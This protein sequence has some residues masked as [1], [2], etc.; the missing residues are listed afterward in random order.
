MARRFGVPLSTVQLWVKRAGDT[1]L[2]DVDW[3]DRSSAPARTRRVET[4]VEDRVLAAR[5]YLRD[6]TALG[7]WGAVAIHGHLIHAFGEAPSVRTIGRI[8]ER[9]GALDGSARIRR[10]PPKPGWYLK[11]VRERQAEL[12]SFDTVMGLV[13][14]NG[15]EV[16]VL[17]GVSLHGGVVA[18]WP[19]T[20][21]TARDTVR[22][23]VE[24]WREM[25]L[26]RYAQFD[27]DTRFQ[28]A[29]HHRDA[30][31]RVTRLCLSLGVVPVFVP[32]R[33]PGFQGAIE[34]YNG[35][36]QAKVWNRFHH[37]SLLALQRRSNAYVRAKRSRG[38]VRAEAA[39][40]RRQFPK[41][42][43]LDLNQPLRGRVVYIRRTNDASSVEL[44]GHRFGVRTEWPHRLVRADIELDEHIIHFY[45]LRRRDPEHQPLLR[46]TRY[47]PP[48][49]RFR[50]RGG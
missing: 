21:V 35:H 5:R 29:H 15:P 2:E 37:V 36:W 19:T 11:D 28:G 46:S 20:G 6:R 22:F 27:N 38:A 40:P 47:L 34:S 48:Q 39:P 31:G 1:Q 33:E 13:I 41:R 9:R 50:N 18:S 4:D 17:N 30:F 32:P 42:W 8:L 14:A 3:G 26:P 43:A 16:E 12:D 25:G 49:Q 24:H 45:A 44:L 23:L 7:E 10:P